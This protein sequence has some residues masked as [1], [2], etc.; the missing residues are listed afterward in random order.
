[1]NINKKNIIINLLKERNK[2]SANICI[3]QVLSD[4]RNPT[5]DDSGQGTYMANTR[6]GD[7]LAQWIP[8]FLSRNRVPTPLCIQTKTVYLT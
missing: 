5:P 4:V 8:V 3:K 6:R 2:G 1:M 7:L